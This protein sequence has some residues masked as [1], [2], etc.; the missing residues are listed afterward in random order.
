VVR[1]GDPLRLPEIDLIVE[2]VRLRQHAFPLETTDQ[3]IVVVLLNAGDR[4]TEVR[5]IGGE[6]TGIKG[7]L[8]TF[9]GVPHCPNRH[10][11][12]EDPGIRLGWIAERKLNDDRR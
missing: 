11:L 10:A 1:A 4:Y 2:A 12:L 9:D 6:W 5:C 7:D 3:S 8:P